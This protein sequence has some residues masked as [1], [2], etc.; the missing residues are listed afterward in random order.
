MSIRPEATLPNKL[1]FQA[2]EAVD[3][4]L[5]HVRPE[6]ETKQVMTW[7]ERGKHGGKCGGTCGGK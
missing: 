1:L 4:K 6:R 2:L 3:Q 7:T 5:K